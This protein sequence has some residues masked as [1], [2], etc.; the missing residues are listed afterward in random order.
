MDETDY[1]TKQITVDG[2]VQTYAKYYQPEII[3]HHNYGGIA[4]ETRYLLSYNCV[5]T[6]SAL[7]AAAYHIA[8][9]ALP[10]NT[11]VTIHT[12]WARVA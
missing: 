8:E 7:V 9:E 12:S 1:K 10:K 2:E 3:E 4:S 6:E 5:D 11:P